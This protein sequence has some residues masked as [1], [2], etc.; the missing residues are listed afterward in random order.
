M[1][2]LHIDFIILANKGPKF[3]AHFFSSFL[4]Q[5]MWKFPISELIFEVPFINFFNLLSVLGVICSTVSVVWQSEDNY[6]KSGLF[7]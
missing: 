3:S 7:T 6:G 1:G 2:E 5:F 4:F